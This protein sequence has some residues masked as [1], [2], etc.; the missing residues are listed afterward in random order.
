MHQRSRSGKPSASPLE[1]HLGFW[2]RYVS[3]HVSTRFQT[4][5]EA[6][7][8]TVSDWVALR[9]LWDAPHSTHASL[10]QALG[11]TKGAASKI[12]SRLEERGLAHRL[13][14][15]GSGREQVLALTPAGRRLVPRLAALADANDAHCFAPL[16]AAQREALQQ[17]LQQLVHAHGLQEIPVR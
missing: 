13:L 8:V 11:M 16:S 4:L 17:S 15:E 9:T 6:E 3:N 2:L 7:G 14:A 10:I 12:V 1:A 5:I